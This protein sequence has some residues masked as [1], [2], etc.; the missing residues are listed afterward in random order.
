MKTLL[1]I[2][3]ICLSLSSC[4]KKKV[5]PI[6]PLPPPSPE[7]I[8]G[9]T[10]LVADYHTYNTQWNDTVRVLKTNNSCQDKIKYKLVNLAGAFESWGVMIQDRIYYVPVNTMEIVDTLKMKLGNDYIQISVKQ[11]NGIYSPY[12]PLTEVN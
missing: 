2:L 10:T 11:Q 8:A 3:I 4:K 9:D 5:E 7:C 12:L 6:V 1:T